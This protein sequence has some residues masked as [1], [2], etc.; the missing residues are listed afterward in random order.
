MAGGAVLF[1]FNA[2]EK[3]LPR[4]SPTQE[5]SHSL[6]DPPARVSL[7]ETKTA[8][9]ADVCQALAFKLTRRGVRLIVSTPFTDGSRS[10]RGE[11]PGAHPSI[12]PLPIG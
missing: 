1:L 4:A 11:I 12:G 6:D 10:L 8:A 7:H 2:I 3:K 5:L 9:R